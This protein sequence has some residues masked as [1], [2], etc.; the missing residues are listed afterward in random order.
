MTG[1]VDSG[2]VLTCGGHSVPFHDLI[3]V[4]TDVSK[5]AEVAEVAEVYSNPNVKDEE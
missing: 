4:P 3:V 5:V 1:N 2:P